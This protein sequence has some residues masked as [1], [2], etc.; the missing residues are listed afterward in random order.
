MMNQHLHHR[1]LPRLQGYDYRQDGAYFVTICT[2]NRTCLFGN[3]IAGEMMLNALGR[4][5]V[6][7]WAQIPVHFTHVELDAYRVMPNHL[8]GIILI[9][10][11]MLSQSGRQETFSRPAKGSLASVIRTFKAAVTRSANSALMNTDNSI[12]W[13]GRYH[14]HIIRNEQSLNQIREYIV[15]NPLHWQDDTLFGDL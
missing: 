8:H 7:C 3:I 14:D 4:I 11:E 9:H 6:S 10:A 5:V 13:Q 12:I 15:H 1:K 2:H